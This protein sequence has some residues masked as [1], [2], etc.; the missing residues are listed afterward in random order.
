MLRIDPKTKGWKTY[1]EFASLGARKFSGGVFNPHDERV[2]CVPF[3]AH[4]VLTVDP[5]FGTS[6]EQFRGELPEGHA[7][8]K[9]SG[10][11]MAPNGSIYC[12]P[13]NARRVLR[14]DTRA[15]KASALD[16]EFPGFGKWSGGVL[17]NDGCI[18]GVPHSAGSVLRIDPATGE[19]TAVAQVPTEPTGSGQTLKWRGGVL[20]NNGDVYA[21]P[22]DARRAL[23]MHTQDLA[24]QIKMREAQEQRD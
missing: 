16:G 14:I 6:A 19:A 4:S 1:G 12:I 2:W 24:N 18:Y 3:D 10:G 23:L 5:E 7:R 17:A 15:R 22:C 9:W 11:V 20:A 21:I 8:G 13:F